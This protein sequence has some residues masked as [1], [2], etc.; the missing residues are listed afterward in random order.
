MW[1]EITQDKGLTQ[2]LAHNSH[3]I[4]SK[5]FRQA[6]KPRLPQPDLR[7]PIVKRNW[8]DIAFRQKREASLGTHGGCPGEDPAPD[9]WLW[10]QEGL[11]LQGTQHLSRW[12]GFLL[13]LFHYHSPF[14]S[15]TNL[16][17]KHT[18][19]NSTSLLGR[20]R[21]EFL[22]VILSLVIS[23]YICLAQQQAFDKYVQ[24]NWKVEYLQSTLNF[25]KYVLKLQYEFFLRH[26]LQAGRLCSYW[27]GS[28]DEMTRPR[29]RG[30]APGPSH[31][32][33]QPP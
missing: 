20:A 7:W 32:F 27:G 14:S 1:T 25:S 33:P 13:P 9:R 18:W 8:L 24:N 10:G 15:T 12:H 26:V 6:L 31:S 11:R 2:C 5:G 19:L 23:Y 28:W 30:A 3:Q 17:F 21:Y 16:S 4:T 29:P 22:I